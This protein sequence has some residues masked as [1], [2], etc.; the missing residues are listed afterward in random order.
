VSDQ[1]CIPE[2]TQ[3][4]ALMGNPDDTVGFSKLL[5]RSLIDESWRLNAII[6]GRTVAA[7]YQWQRCVDETVEVYKRVM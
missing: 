7:S 5:E 3:G 1:S 2:I 6:V 4:A